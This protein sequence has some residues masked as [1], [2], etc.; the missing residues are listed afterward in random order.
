METT[1]D[2]PAGNGLAAVKESLDRTRHLLWMVGTI[3]IVGLLVCVALV[4][5]A[6]RLNNQSVQNRQ[7]REAIYVGC[8]SGNQARAQQKQLWEEVIN[9]TA[10]PNQT[11]AQQAVV[12]TF[13]RYLNNSLKPRDCGPD[14]N[15]P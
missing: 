11:P 13:Q 5:I 9:L 14:P 1:V 2:H 6:F 12:G 7:T 4:F 10:R 3:F 15:G 8:Q